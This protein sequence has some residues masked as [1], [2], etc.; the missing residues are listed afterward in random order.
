[1]KVTALVLGKFKDLSFDLYCT[2]ET[3]FASHT[4]K[5]N[6]SGELHI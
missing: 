6:G 4:P 2:S 3:S 1:M 5:R